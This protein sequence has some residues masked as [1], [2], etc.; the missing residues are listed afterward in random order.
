MLLHL[1]SKHR[2]QVIQEGVLLSCA[3]DSS[4]QAASFVA[5]RVLSAFSM[6]GEPGTRVQTIPRAV[7]HGIPGSPSRMRL[8]KAGSPSAARARSVM[9]LRRL[10]SAKG[11]D[12]LIA[13]RS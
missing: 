7:F 12:V 6:L 4:H 13:P 9:W 3:A 10:S 1:V 2:R 8:E 5:S 11:S